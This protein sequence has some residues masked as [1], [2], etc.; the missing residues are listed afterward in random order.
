MVQKV[1]GGGGRGGKKMTKKTQDKA[2]TAFQDLAAREDQLENDK[3]V[4]K[5]AEELL[6]CPSKIG[7]CLRYVMTDFF[8]PGHERDGQEPPFSSDYRRLHRVP[9]DH[10]RTRTMVKCCSKLT[11]SVCLALKKANGSKTLHNLL[12]LATLLEPSDKFGP[13]EKCAWGN[14]IAQRRSAALEPLKRL[15]WDS[16]NRIDWWSSSV[17]E[18]L[19]AIGED[20]SSAHVYKQVKLLGFEVALVSNVP[21][22]RTMTLMNALSVDEC[23]I[24]YCTSSSRSHRVYPKDCFLDCDGFLNKFKSLPAAID[25]DAGQA[26]SQADD[27][28]DDD[29]KE[30]PK[31]TKKSTDA[32]KD[33]SQ[34]KA[35]S[36]SEAS[37]GGKPTCLQSK[38]PSTV[39]VVKLPDAKKPKISP[40]ALRVMKEAKTA[41]A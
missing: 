16:G 30:A 41:V 31:D 4:L 5:I 32:N 27:D 25:D 34:G 39:V 18:F 7:R 19:P 40:E 28:D 26:D 24:Q 17:F 21:I 6:R 33:K 8:L 22:K 15:T 3:N 37:K 29:N 14:W 10:L 12:Y 13:R 35:S 2:V 23:Y 38:V 11:A 20:D 1:S 9:Q 36:S